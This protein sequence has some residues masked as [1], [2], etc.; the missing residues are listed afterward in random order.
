MI[1]QDK[2]DVLERK[3]AWIF[4]ETIQQAAVDKSRVMVAVPG[5]RSVV[6]LLKHLQHE[7]V[8]WEKVHIFMVDERI[9]PPD[10]PDSNYRLVSSCLE[11]VA[12]AARLYPLPYSAEDAS[13][14][15]Q[16]Y[17]ERLAALGGRYDVVLLASGE[18]GHVAGLFP[19]HETVR[20]EESFFV[21]TE[22]APKP[23]PLRMTSS[24]KLIAASQTAILL[25]LGNEKHHAFSR[26][27]DEKVSLDQCPVKIVNSV[28][29]RYILTDY[30]Y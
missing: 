17:Q 2:R 28:P 20:S 8:D 4:A 26:Y 5:G 27:R 25:F 10:H 14:G 22:T 11:E 24:R 9:V 21:I 30:G 3:G 13:Y 7:Y 19:Q 29:N 23:P 18:D 12:G 16:H 15:V 6:A 1:I